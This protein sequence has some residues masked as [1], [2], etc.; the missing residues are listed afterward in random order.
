MSSSKA[1]PIEQLAEGDRVRI[2]EPGL[3]PRIYLGS[4]G[5]IKRVIPG[6]EHVLYTV[7]FDEV[8][9][10]FWTFPA[11]AIALVEAA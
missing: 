10:G 9:L 3:A 2:A 4:V 6:Q 11:S 5:T 7:L 1:A 8:R